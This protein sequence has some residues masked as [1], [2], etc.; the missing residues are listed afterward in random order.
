MEN[1]DKLD[2]W[3]PLFSS[4][5]LSTV[6]GEAPHTKIVWITLLALKNKNG[7]V[8][9][10]VP[11]LARAAVVSTEECR[12]ALRVLEAPDPDSKNHENDGRRISSVDGGWVVLGHRRFQAL[13]KDVSAKIAN[14]KR[15]AK[16]RAK[17]KESSGGNGQLPGEAAYEA[18]VDDGASLAEQDA[19]VTSRLP[20]SAQ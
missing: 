1:E 3:T 19:I 5:V 7:F 12:D 8:A 2:T 11:G 10:S 17:K 15:Q 6:W 14:A 16:F 18:A 13:M 4:I 20:E 9:G